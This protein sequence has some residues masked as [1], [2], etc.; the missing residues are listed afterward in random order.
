MILF[1]FFNP[2][3]RGGGS[4]QCVQSFEV[5]KFYILLSL[6]GSLRGPAPS[7]RG[8]VIFSPMVKYTSTY[9]ADKIVVRF[10]WSHVYNYINTFVRRVMRNKCYQNWVSTFG[11]DD[12]IRISPIFDHKT[13][14]PF[15]TDRLALYAYILDSACPEVPKY[16]NG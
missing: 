1:Y 12:E 14:N 10:D 7:R 8:R 6:C 9:L 11:E 4:P 2:E 16:L 5:A 3:G 15:P 13:R